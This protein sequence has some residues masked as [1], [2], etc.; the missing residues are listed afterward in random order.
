MRITN[1]EV[2]NSTTMSTAMTYGG[3]VDRVHKGC[4]L[5]QLLAARVVG[6]LGSRTVGKHPSFDD[7]LV[8]DRNERL[9]MRASV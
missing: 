8:E 7:L 3:V 4:D 9:V 1:S 5:L 6:R 2:S